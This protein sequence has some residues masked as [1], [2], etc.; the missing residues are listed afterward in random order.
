MSIP[1]VVDFHPLRRTQRRRV[2]P[3]LR[4]TEYKDIE[5]FENLP[6]SYQKSYIFVQK[7]FYSLLTDGTPWPKSMR[8]RLREIKVNGAPVYTAAQVN[9]IP[10]DFREITEEKMFEENFIYH[11]AKSYKRL[12]ERDKSALSVLSVR[13]LFS[14]FFTV[15]RL[16]KNGRPEVFGNTDVKSIRARDEFR[17]WVTDTIDSVKIMRTHKIRAISE[18][19]FIELMDYTCRDKRSLYDLQIE[20]MIIFHTAFHLRVGTQLNTV[21]MNHVKCDS[22]NGVFSY[23]PVRTKEQSRSTLRISSIVH[24]LTRRSHPKQFT[25]LEMYFRFRTNNEMKVKRYVFN[26]L[27]RDYKHIL[28]CKALS[29]LNHNQRSRRNRIKWFMSDTIN[30]KKHGVPFVRIKTRRRSMRDENNQSIRNAAARCKDGGYVYCKKG[31]LK[32]KCVS[33]GSRNKMFWCDKAYTAKSNYTKL[34]DR[35]KNKPPHVCDE[36][37]KGPVCDDVSDGDDSDGDDV[38]DGPI[39]NKHKDDTGQDSEDEDTDNDESTDDDDDEPTDDDDDDDD[40]DESNDDDDD[41]EVE[42]ESENDD[43]NEQEENERGEQ[44]DN[45]DALISE[46]VEIGERTKNWLKTQLQKAQEYAYTQSQRSNISMYHGGVFKN[47]SLRMFKARLEQRTGVNS[48]GSKNNQAVYASEQRVFSDLL[49]SLW[50][51]PSQTEKKE[52]VFVGEGRYVK[53]IQKYE[54]KEGKWKCDIEERFTPAARVAPQRVALSCHED[55]Y[56]ETMSEQERK[57][58]EMNI[59]R[60]DDWFC[61]HTDNKKKPKYDEI[62]PW[63]YVAE[64]KAFICQIYKA[65]LARTNIKS[66]LIMLKVEMIKRLPKSDRTNGVL[67]LRRFNC[68]DKEMCDIRLLKQQLRAR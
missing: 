65:N 60:G 16:S 34:H 19:E 48:W 7:R 12:S 47:S 46:E 33:K 35:I 29:L 63:L 15:W 14:K 40:E 51:G 26:E 6:E 17:R 13:N 50:P 10:L 42:Q 56:D 64:Q 2:N 55:E 23:R 36:N 45:E 41:D 24:T 25:S 37:Y 57:R 30:G 20:C 5:G 3:P 59:E 66:N 4:P 49:F 21:R 58:R 31:R 44:E 68:F 18:I 67:Y 1:A 62:I 54:R 22:Y 32:G 28:L 39:D 38:S 52:K 53:T 8:E 43:N 9:E 61:Y 27:H 11:L